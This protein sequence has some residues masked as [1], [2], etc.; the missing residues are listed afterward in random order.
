MLIHT[1]KARLDKTYMKEENVPFKAEKIMVMRE[2]EEG[3]GE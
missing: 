1:M 2:E 3:W